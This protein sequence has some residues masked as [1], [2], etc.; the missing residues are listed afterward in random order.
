M[1]YAIISEDV[2]NSTPPRQSA[3][4]EHTERLNNMLNQ[5]SVLPAGPHPAVDAE[6]PGETGMSGDLIVADFDSLE[7]A[8]QWADNDPFTLAGVYKRVTVKPFRKIIP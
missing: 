7:D 2:E 5:G 4:A 6:E 3:R 8:Q 1:Y